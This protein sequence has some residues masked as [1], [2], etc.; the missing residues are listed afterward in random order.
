[1]V[2]LRISGT[3]VTLLSVIGAVQNPPIAAPKNS[4]AQLP[5][6]SSGPVCPWFT[7]RSAVTAL[8]GDV[9]VTL[10]LATGSQGVCTFNKQQ[11][12]EDELKVIV[13]G[14]NVPS[15]PPGSAKV[16]GVGTRANRCRMT[17]SQGEVQ[18]MIGGAVREKNFAVIIAMRADPS[19]SSSP[20]P[21]T[22]I[23]QQVAE[24]VAGNLF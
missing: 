15:C 4:P 2:P 10:A 8:G 1:M 24:Q 23:L 6:S 14:N 11:S 12:P 3:M 17:A 20:R 16:V 5:A 9:R 13:G 7:E 21:K 18:E 22:D 19:A